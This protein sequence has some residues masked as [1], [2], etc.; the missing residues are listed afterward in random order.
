MLSQSKSREHFRILGYDAKSLDATSSLATLYER[1]LLELRLLLLPGDVIFARFLA[2]RLFQRVL[3]HLFMRRV[4]I[5]PLYRVLLER[6]VP[7][8]SMSL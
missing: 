7:P 8:L 1:T 6:I 5:A 2:V 3:L 4:D